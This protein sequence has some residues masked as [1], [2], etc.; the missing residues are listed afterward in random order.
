MAFEIG[1][2]KVMVI[3]DEPFIR[4][5]IRRLL[6]QLGVEDVHEAN[7]GGAGLK[8]VVRIRPHLIFCDIHMEPV[9]GLTFLQKLRAL[10]MADIKS[11]PVVFLTADSQEETVLKARSLAVNGYLVK[12]VSPAALQARIQAI[13]GS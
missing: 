6:K 12:P 7:E 9:D 2:A 4:T 8:E 3:E 13:L 1:K 11:I 5:L 10:P